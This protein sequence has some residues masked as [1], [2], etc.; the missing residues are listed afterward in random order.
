MENQRTNH[1][2]WHME[3]KIEHQVKPM[4]ER[5]SIRV[6]SHSMDEKYATFGDYLLRVPLHHHQVLGV[7]E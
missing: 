4:P 2:H 3:W 7:S 6:D 1:L 5:N